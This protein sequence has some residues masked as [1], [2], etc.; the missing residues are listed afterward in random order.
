MSDATSGTVEGMQG[1]LDWAREKG[2]MNASTAQALKSTVGKVV[3]VADDGGSA[4]V[5]NLDVENLL[6]RW[7]TKNKAKYKVDT[8]NT[9]KVRFRQAVALYGAWL[10]NDPDWK[11]AS[12][13]ANSDVSINRRGKR[14]SADPKKRSGAPTLREQEPPITEISISTI[15]TRLVSYDLPLRPDLLVR[16]NLP[17]DLTRDDASRISAFV[18]SLAFSPSPT[19]SDDAKVSSN[20]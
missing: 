3:E 7:E 16:L 17:V 11:A 4:V 5:A 12:K 20:G 1:F 9:Y 6:S 13:A 14:V 15:G 18:S 2:E 10:A 19:T 8:L